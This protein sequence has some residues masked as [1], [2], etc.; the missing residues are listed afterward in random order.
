MENGEQPAGLEGYQ[1]AESIA[2]AERVIR[3]C[4][5]GVKHRRSACF[6]SIYTKQHNQNVAMAL[7]S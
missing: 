7:A 5:S 6:V 3:R 2:L 4:L 1:E